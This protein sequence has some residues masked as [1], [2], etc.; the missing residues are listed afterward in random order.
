MAKIAHSIRNVLAL[1]EEALY[2]GCDAAEPILA[3]AVVVDPRVS[4]KCRLNLCGQYGRNLMC[5]PQV[6]DVSQTA[7]ALERY[8]FALL[9]Q[10][11]CKAEPAEY[12]TVFDRE[13]AAMNAIVVGLEQEAFRRGFSLTLGLGCGHCQ[14]CP[15]CAGDDGLFVCRHPAQARPSMEAVGIDVQKTCETAGLAAGFISGQ[16]TSTGLLLVD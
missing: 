5:P 10:I 15:V 11:T 4:L 12:R 16:V 14:L 8:T 1:A 3:R 2:K 6:W 13:K 7:A 9:L